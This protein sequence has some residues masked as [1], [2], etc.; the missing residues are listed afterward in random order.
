MVLQNLETFR[1]LFHERLK[2]YRKIRYRYEKKYNR[3]IISATESK[4]ED[5]AEE[6]AKKQNKQRKKRWGEQQQILIN[7][8]K[9]NCPNQNTIN[10]NDLE[11]SDLTKSLLRKGPSY[12]PS[13]KDITVIN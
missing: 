6:N 12:V 5:S 1:T 8:T 7:E 3:D 4:I 10:L 11:I 2:I 13:P 9:Q